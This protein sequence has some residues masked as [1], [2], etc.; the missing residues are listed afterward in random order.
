MTSMRCHHLTDW[1]YALHAM[2]TSAPPALT[3]HCWLPDLNPLATGLVTGAGLVGSFFYAV[4]AAVSWSAL[5]AGIVGLTVLVL[6]LT[7]SR[8]TVTPEVLTIVGSGLLHRSRYTCPLAEVVLE[9]HRALDKQRIPYDASPPP[10][11]EF[12]SDWDW[13]TPT[14]YLTI[15]YQGESITN[16]IRLSQYAAIQAAVATMVAHRLARAA[17]DNY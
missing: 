6:W 17:A 7:Y 11:L 12:Y 9:H 15:K 1:P 5:V 4:A 13:D 16:F 10:L 8:V 2:P 3:I 14:D